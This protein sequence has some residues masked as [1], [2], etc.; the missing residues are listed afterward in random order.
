VRLAGWAGKPVV[1]RV[2]KR[3]PHRDVVKRTK[4]KRGRGGERGGEEGRT[5]QDRTKG[6]PKLQA[7]G[8]REKCGAGL[9][10][11]HKGVIPR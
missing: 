4:G 2:T 6:K 10:S 3:E 7:C 5:G 1:I 11:H 9:L 8:R